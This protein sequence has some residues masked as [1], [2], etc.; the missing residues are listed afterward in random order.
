MHKMLSG[1]KKLLEK[2]HSGEK[3]KPIEFN[4]FNPKKRSRLNRFLFDKV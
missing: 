3:Y 2:I 1:D 4:F